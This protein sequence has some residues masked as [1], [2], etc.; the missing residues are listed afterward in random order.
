[1]QPV[2]PEEFCFTRRAADHGF[3]QHVAWTH[4]PMQCRQIGLRLDHD[5]APSTLVEPERDAARDWMSAADVD[6]ASLARSSE[7]D[8][9]VIIFHVLSVGQR[10]FEGLDGWHHAPVTMG[11]LL[12]R[13]TYH[14][15]PCACCY[16]L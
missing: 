5:P 6:V 15:L 11:S 2:D 4:A 16:A 8:I 9:E 3:D 7:R 12:R 1:M 14:T 13:S 10:S